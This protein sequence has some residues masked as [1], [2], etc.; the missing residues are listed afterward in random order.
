[1]R[2]RRHVV[3]TGL[4]QGVG[5]RFACVREAERHGVDGWVRN[6]SD[7]TVEA[8]LEGEEAAVSALLAWLHEGPDGAD[9]TGVDV[10]TEDPRGEAGFEQH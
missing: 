6:R 1:M 9:V 10:R 2:Q 4:V 5:M 3:V 7:G 8:V